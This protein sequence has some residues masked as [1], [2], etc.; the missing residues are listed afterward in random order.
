[1]PAS[2][3]TRNTKMKKQHGQQLKAIIFDMDN[4]LFDFVKAKL[5]A[6]AAVVTI[7]GRRDDSALLDYF[8]NDD[9]DVERFESI[10][11]YLKDR[12]IYS[13]AK[14]EECT[15]LY[16]K[17][18][19]E[20]IELYPGVMET[21][22]EIKSMNLGSAVVTDAFKANAQ[23]RL[24]KTGLLQ[25]F[26]YV[27]T[28]D[29]VGTKKPEPDSIIYA[30]AKLGCS[31]EEAIFIGDSLRRDIIPSNKLGLVTVY[32]AYG[33]RNFYEDRRGSADHTINDIRELIPVIKKYMKTT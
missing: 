25:Y 16:Y 1:M 20:N 22:N 33:D 8:I 24:R 4:T 17:T 30:L 28:A 23:A 18:K 27:I 7:V 15:K 21:L 10:A 29:L 11:E 3:G 13:D 14:F 6:C 31:A 2:N 12:D 26:D 5:L 32:A 9:I 19:M